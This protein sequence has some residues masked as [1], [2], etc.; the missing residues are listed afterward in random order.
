[1][2]DSPS[3]RWQR[4][5]R[6]YNE[7]LE[8]H[9]SDRDAFLARASEG[10]EGLQREVRSLLDYENAAGGF[11]ERPAVVEAAHSLAGETRPPLS[12]RCIA[13]YDVMALVGGGGMG[14][15]YRA[16]DRRL[17]RE[18]AFKVLE[19]TIAA[20]PE[21]RR[22][23]EHEA[24]AA[25][26][27]NHPNVVTI[28]NVAEEDEVTF[29]TMELV[30]GHTLRRHL[31]SGPLRLPL[32]LDVSV[33]LAS[34]L[35]AAHTLGIVHRDLKPENIMITPDGL[36]KVLDFGLAK[37]D[38]VS[39]DHGTTVG[40]LAYMSP[41]QALG[42]PAGPQSDQFVDATYGRSD[43]WSVSAGLPYVFAEYWARDQ[44]TYVARIEANLGRPLDAKLANL[45][46]LLWFDTLHSLHADNTCGGCHS[47][48]NGFG[49][50]QP[51]AI[52]VQNNG[53]VGPH[54]SGPRNQ[55]R[56]PLVINTALYPALMWNGRFNSL[57]GDPFDNSRGFRFPFPED[58]RRFSHANDVAQGIT[59][60]LQAQA[61]MPPTELI[62]VAGFTGTC[63]GGVPD[64]TLGSAF[65]QFD[66]GLGD[67]VP[68]PVRRPGR[69]T[70]RSGGRRSSC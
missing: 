62:E 24:Q 15:V 21:Y 13:G 63:P 29:I 57:S 7:A 54:R 48:T 55:R 32:A 5:E 51:M 31:L 26:A 53:L 43:R 33:Q 39:V 69:A 22:R 70:S 45:G 58:D 60:L 10:D 25:S 56:S 12:G 19:P 2:T 14:E 49:D 17:G 6:L 16:R 11:L 20:D 50:S 66:D 9:A 30:Q 65:C 61:H 68:L 27:L 52:G 41:E 28:Y 35:S 59:H 44:Q 18:V 36:V 38:D 46:R 37:R 34:A 47:P 23:F 1:V 8:L 67:A 40:T 64:A 4:I 42:R 3:E